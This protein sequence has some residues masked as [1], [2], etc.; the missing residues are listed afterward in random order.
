MR[1][2][3]LT[4]SFLEYSIHSSS[5][6]ALKPI[7]Q[8]SDC[9]KIHLAGGIS[10]PLH[11]S[12]SQTQRCRIH[13]QAWP[14]RKMN[15]QAQSGT[16]KTRW[17]NIFS[18]LIVNSLVTSSRPGSG[19]S[20]QYE[21]G[22][23]QGLFLSGGSASCHCGL[24]GVTDNFDCNRRVNKD[25]LNWI[26]LNWIKCTSLSSSPLDPVQRSRPVLNGF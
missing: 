20:P 22:P 23:Y 18:S 4:Q 19:G 2:I 26:K 8:T 24:L 9:F 21:S 12:I 17:S 3:F 5:T 13:L 15:Q 7:Y 16:F 10:I 1:Y 25:D 14:C 11:S 6:S